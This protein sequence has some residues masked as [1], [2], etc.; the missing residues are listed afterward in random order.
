MSL[1]INAVV[2]S[3]L[4]T[5]LFAGS[6]VVFASAPV[7]LAAANAVGLSQGKLTAEPSGGASY[8]LPIVVSPGSAGIQP[9]LAFQYSSGGRNGALGVGWSV[10]GV[11]AISRAPQTRAQDGGIHGVDM[12]LADR[13]SLDGQ[14]LIAIVGADGYAGS[15]YRTEINSFTKVISNGASGNGP[16]TFTARTKSGLI[17]TFGGANGASYI[18]PGRTDGTILTWLVSK[19]QDH[20][21]NYMTFSYTSEGNLSSVNYT[22]NDGAGLSSYASVVFTYAASRP[23]PATGYVAGSAIRMNQRLSRVISYYGSQIVRQYDL[24]YEVS[25]NTGKSRLISITEGT[26]TQTYPPTVF[27]WDN[28]PNSIMVRSSL[29][30]DTQSLNNWVQGDFDGDGLC[31]TARAS[32]NKIQIYKVGINGLVATG[33]FTSSQTFDSTTDTWLQS[34]FDGDGKLDLVRVHGQSGNPVVFTLFTNTGTNGSGTAF[35]QSNATISGATHNFYPSHIYMAMDVNG[36]GKLDIVCI[37]GVDPLTGNPQPLKIKVFLNNPDGNAPGTLVGQTWNYSSAPNDPATGSPDDCKQNDQWFAGDFNG[38]GLADLAKLM[39]DNSTQSVRV[40]LNQNGSYLA[41]HWINQSGKFFRSD[42]I[43]RAYT[44]AVG[45]FN[46]DGLIDFVRIP[47]SNNPDNTTTA[48]VF[49]STGSVSTRFTAAQAWLTLTA[50]ERGVVQ[51]GDYNGDGRS[52]LTVISDYFESNSTLDPALDSPTVDDSALADPADGSGY[53]IDSVDSSAETVAST[54]YTVTTTRDVYLSNGG[55]FYLASTGPD[56]V[57]QSSSPKPRAKNLTADFTGD[58]KEDLIRIFATYLNIYLSNPG[59]Q[60][61]MRSITDGMGAKTSVD[62]QP[63][64]GINGIPVFTK[65]TDAVRPAIDLIE[66]MPVVASIAYDNGLGAVGSAGSTYSVS[67]RYEGLKADPLRGMLGFRAIEAIDNRV[68]DGQASTIRVHTKSWLKQGFPYTGMLERASSYLAAASA[69]KSLTDHSGLL[70]DAITL[71]AAGPTENAKVY[72]P[73]AQDSHVYSWDLTGAQTN[74]TETIAQQMDAYGNTLTSVVKTRNLPSTNFFIKTTTSSYDVSTS[75]WRIGQ[76]TGSSVL[77]QAPGQPN[78]TRT[79]GFGY[80][81]N[82]GQV[83]SETVEPDGASWMSTD[84][85]SDAF[86]NGKKST[87]TG[88]DIVARIHPTNQHVR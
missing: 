45:D 26:G 25:A 40:Y 8:Q 54:G 88:N 1:K 6:T 68:V 20:A 74:D 66:P 24:A 56:M 85:A 15:G 65:S 4:L 47:K 35:T 51:A 31:D 5:L 22:M 3:Q 27:T 21:G 29:A 30:A 50:P 43:T 59:Y 38:D 46:G 36:D 7:R 72:F 49:L 80:N 57:M 73:Y 2:N 52:D 16:A 75:N 9:K 81:A 67:Y 62:Y 79:S 32:G 39:P 63:L 71:Y 55:G 77:S 82:N 58:G 53:N 61:L 48:D 44:W 64:T 12:T 83:G 37:N 13:Y 19:V 11:S 84:Y 41:A 86:G 42:G 34:D 87:S 33:S 76:V 60:D 78:V 17:Y 70:S 69:T 28:D 10:S 18:P 14:R 23:D